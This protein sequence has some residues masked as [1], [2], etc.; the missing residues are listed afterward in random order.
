MPQHRRRTTTPSGTDTETPTS[1][2]S[3]TETSPDNSRV[4]DTFGRW[5]GTE[6]SGDTEL[7]PLLQAAGQEVQSQDLLTF[8]GYEEQWHQSQDALIR[9]VVAEFNEEKGWEEGDVHYLDPNMVKAWALQESGGH[10][11]IFSGGDM[12]QVNNKGDWAKEKTQFGMTK[13]EQ[14]TPESSLRAA[15]A[16]AY[17]KG[18]TTRAKQGED[19]GEGWHDTQRGSKSLP[20][21]ESRFTG[22]KNALEDYNGGGVAH[23]ED[24]ILARLESGEVPDKQDLPGPMSALDGP[25]ERLA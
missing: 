6:H 3:S 22:W 10:Q 25:Q 13:G 23:Y 9:Q 11:S 1:T 15:L 24:E 4:L 5:L 18:E 7:G 2:R 21:Y 16:W 12:M 8:P 20:G 17:Y 19:N 14:M